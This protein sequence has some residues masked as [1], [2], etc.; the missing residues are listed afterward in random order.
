M[1]LVQL[2]ALSA[3]VL[4]TAIRAHADGVSTDD[5]RVIVGSG[6]DPGSP[7]NCE[8]P[9]TINPHAH[10]GGGITNCMNPVT[11]G[12]DV[13]GLTIMG[14]AKKGSFMFGFGPLGGVMCSMGATA[15]NSNNLFT[16]CTVNSEMPV[17]GNSGQVMVTFTLSGGIVPPELGVPGEFFINLNDNANN[18]T[19]K[20]PAMGGKGSWIGMMLMVDPITAPVPV[21]EPG[22]MTL[23][24]IGLGGIWFWRKRHASKSNA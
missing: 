22:T 3:L 10:N 7:I 6:G 12:E 13:I 4:F 1:K 23:F 11:S 24:L 14:I 5:F 15:F 16:M 18:T 19:G 8:V 17:H 21:P 9:F 20:G 2:L